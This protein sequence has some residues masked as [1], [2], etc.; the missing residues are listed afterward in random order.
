[1]IVRSLTGTILV[2]ALVAG[3]TRN[4]AAQAPPATRL[5][6]SPIT[7][8]GVVVR[9]IDQSVARHAD[10][11]GVPAPPVR[12]TAAFRTA[13]FRLANIAIELLQPAAGTRAWREY[14]EK[15]GDS[16]HHVGLGVTSVA[17]ARRAAAA[18]GASLSTVGDFVF[19]DVAGVGFAIE[20]DPVSR[21]AGDAALPAAS[22]GANTAVHVSAILPD[23]EAAGRALAAFLQTDLPP[24]VT[25]KMGSLTYPDDYR[26]D[27]DASPQHVTFG[28]KNMQLELTEPQGGSS[29][30]RDQL[31]AHGTAL[32][33]VAFRVG[34]MAAAVAHLQSKGGVLV[35]G[36]PSVTYAYVNL[37][38]APLG[39]TIEL[40]GP[41]K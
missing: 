20:L 1:M 14:L 29:P 32:H 33:H 36:G 35:L 24:T 21:L 38:P 7:H 8:V 31:D 19:A 9:D 6:D 34:D 15:H 2:L 41:R 18:L 27:R 13:V 23:V 16:I 30:W 28:M 26:R 40:N 22:F 10:L 3:V 12:G 37:A 5:A 4:S 11:F 39:M 25:V 17:D